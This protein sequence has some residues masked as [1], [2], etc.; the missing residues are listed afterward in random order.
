MSP[1]LTLASL[2]LITDIPLKGVEQQPLLS[3]YDL[4][5]FNEVNKPKK[6]RKNRCVS[7]ATQ[8]VCTT[9]NDY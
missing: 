3:L 6:E 4:F 9:A 7:S 8:S 5:A 1:P 2:P